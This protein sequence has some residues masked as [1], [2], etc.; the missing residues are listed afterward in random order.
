MLE[1][2]QKECSF[3]KNLFLQ[4]FALVMKL[5]CS[6]KVDTSKSILLTNCDERLNFKNR[7]TWCILYAILGHSF[8]SKLTDTTAFWGHVNRI[9]KRLVRTFG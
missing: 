7:G 1:V 8:N 2:M 4:S 3:C 9:V 5:V 6:R